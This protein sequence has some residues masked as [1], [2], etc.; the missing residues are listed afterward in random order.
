MSA[1]VNSTSERYR[2]RVFTLVRAGRI[3][4]AKTIAGL[5]MAQQHLQQVQDAGL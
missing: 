3:R 2:G 4:D 5:F 1:T